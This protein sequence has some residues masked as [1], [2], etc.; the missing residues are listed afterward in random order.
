MVVLILVVLE[1]VDESFL[2]AWSQF[3]ED[4]SDRI[5]QV[6]SASNLFSACLVVFVRAFQTALDR[7]RRRLT[8]SSSKLLC[9]SR[10]QIYATLMNQLCSKKRCQ[11]FLP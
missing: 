1:Q 8:A 10:S 2:N 6:G 4:I 9:E 7:E 5:H 3:L 11:M